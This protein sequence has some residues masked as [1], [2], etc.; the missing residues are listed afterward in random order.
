MELYSQLKNAARV[1][2]IGAG[3]LRIMTFALVTV[4]ILQVYQNLLRSAGDVSMTMIMGFSEVIFRVATAFIFSALFGYIGVWWATPITWAL[5]MIVG[6][7]RYFT[8][9][10]K[11]KGLIKA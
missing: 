6:V 2:E 8:G 10:W 11:S 9:G 4:G 3:Y 7:I 5:A 1:I